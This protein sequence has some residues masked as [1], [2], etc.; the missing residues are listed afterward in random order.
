MGIVTTGLGI[1]G[2][3]FVGYKIGQRSKS[4]DRQKKKL[5]NQEDRPKEER[6]YVAPDKAFWDNKSKL[7]PLLRGVSCDGITNKD[8]WTAII[9]EIRN[10]ELSHMWNAG[11]QNHNLWI[12]YLQS[13]GVQMD[14]IT[15]FE[16]MEGF[17]E[18]YDTV[19]GKS[20]E[21]GKE[22]VVVSPCWIFTDTS[23]VK[24]VA[25]RGVVRIKK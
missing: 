10:E 12:T 21:I 25:L 11:M 4:K 24:S 1:V 8:E 9:R 3:V 6:P 20:I 14:I 7:F 2:G 19:D 17:N 16:G 13:F 23:N 22:Y 15:E 18:M 5:S